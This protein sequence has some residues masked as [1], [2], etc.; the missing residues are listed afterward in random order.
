MRS[1]LPARLGRG[2]HGTGR[3]DRPGGVD[4]DR[5]GN[6]MTWNVGHARKKHESMIIIEWQGMK[7][8]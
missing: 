1:K 7:P 2:Q 8:T 4:K 3:K 6:P 5:E